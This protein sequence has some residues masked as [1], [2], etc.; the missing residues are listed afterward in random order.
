MGLLVRL[1]IRQKRI[2]PVPGELQ[3]VIDAILDMDQ[4]RE[5]GNSGDTILFPFPRI[6]GPIAT[7]PRWEIL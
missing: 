1:M 6:C 7:C 3:N 5:F 2:L 4:I